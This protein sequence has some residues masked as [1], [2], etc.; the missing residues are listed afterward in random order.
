MIDRVASTLCISNTVLLY[1][2]IT[3]GVGSS[4]TFSHHCVTSGSAPSCH[5]ASVGSRSSWKPLLPPMAWNNLTTH[6]CDCDPHNYVSL[7]VN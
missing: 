4:S 7:N 2:S 3:S 1:C 6:G 5:N